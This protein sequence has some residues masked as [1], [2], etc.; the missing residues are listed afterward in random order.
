[1]LAGGMD[2]SAMAAMFEGGGGTA[3]AQAN[4]MLTPLIQVVITLL[5]G[6]G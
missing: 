4:R 3:G 1:M 2:P 6:K 5:E